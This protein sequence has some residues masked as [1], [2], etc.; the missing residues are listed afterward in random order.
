MQ[1]EL[2]LAI[3]LAA[4]GDVF[5]KE[6][7]A[8]PPELFPQN[9]T[10][11]YVAS[12]S[13]EETESREPFASLEAIAAKTERGRF[14]DIR[15]A[16]GTAAWY[17]MLARRKAKR[18]WMN[19]IE[20]E[21]ELPARLRTAFAGGVQWAIQVDYPSD[22]ELWSP[23]WKHQGGQKPWKVRCEGLF[24]NRPLP[25]RWRPLRDAKDEL[26]VAVRRAE[27]F[28]SEVQE[29]WFSEQF[30]KALTLLQSDQP[31]P[32][33]HP[34]M[35]PEKGYTIDARRLLAAAA[36]S[37]VFG[38]MGSFNDLGFR[39]RGINRE[40]HQVADRLFSAVL[41]AILSAVNSNQDK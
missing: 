38:G 25:R 24:V 14:Q 21:E 29:D 40:Y 11:Q 20:S 5:L 37:W 32:P 27:G 31:V 13:F 26:E 22:F 28:S 33:Y 7:R 23:Q 9:S 30:R 34:D 15:A 12:I 18:L 17:L 6:T 2:A 10:L 3:A 8:A 39:E 36:A 16:S 19:K 41:D 4:Y 1:G 35:L